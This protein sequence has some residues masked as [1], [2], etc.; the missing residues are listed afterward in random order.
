MS[1]PLLLMILDGWGDRKEYNDNAITLAHPQ[2]FSNLEMNYPHTLLKC[3]GKDVGLPDGLMGN[4]E[5]G[6]LNIGSGRVVYQEISRLFNAIEDHSFFNNPEFLKA[7]EYARAH[8]GSVHLMGLLSD[9]GVHSHIEHIYALLELCAQNHIDSV[10]VHAFLDGRDVGPKT[11]LKFVEA[12]Q[13]KMRAIGCGQIATLGGRYYGMDR[14]KHWDRI[15][16]A[17]NALVLGEG[18]KAANPQAAL[19]NSYENRV[20][21]EFVEPVV[22]VDQD[23]QPVGLIKD[24]DAVL[25]FNF[26]A[27]RAR[28][29]TR[30]F[31]DKDFDGFNR[32]GKPEVYYVCMTQYDV[33]INA[34]AAFMPQNLNNTLGE[35]LS[36]QGFKQLRIAETEKYAHVTFFFN[37]GVEAA[38]PGEDRALIPS[39]SVATY[40]LTPEM[41][42][43]QVTDKLLQELDRDYY[44]VVILNYANADMVGHTGVLEAAVKAVKTVDECLQ[45]VVDRVLSKDGIVLITADHGN[46]EMMVSP[47]TGSP[48]TAHTTSRVPFILVSDQHRNAVLRDNGSLQDIAPTLLSLLNIPIPAE[49]TGRSLVEINSVMSS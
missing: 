33:N 42:A 22:L 36:E 31:V 4:S 24:G 10:F 15:E 46:C 35:V 27:D 23:S 17:Y 7:I 45:K 12:L 37:G 21:D 8:H 29:I 6:H 48:F 20:T 11:A 3:S 14:D 32:K 43:R 39:P 47:E 26:R 2:N 25:F 13:Q 9:G 38:N 5:V 30:A 44:D 16:K 41:S 28:Q 34:P 19:E 18:K 1:R 40:N 49:M